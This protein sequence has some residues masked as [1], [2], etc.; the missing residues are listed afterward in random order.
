MFEFN[1]DPVSRDFYRG[2]WRDH[3][4]SVLFI[5]T[6]D[7]ELIVGFSIYDPEQRRAGKFSIVAYDANFRL[8]VRDYAAVEAFLQAKAYKIFPDDHYSALLEV[9]EIVNVLDETIPVDILT[10]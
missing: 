9:N 8:K 2:K 1:L 4:V 10:R 6:L 7:Q 3:I 5:R